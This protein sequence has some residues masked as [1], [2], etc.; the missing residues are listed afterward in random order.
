MLFQPSSKLPLDQFHT[1]PFSH[2]PGGNIYN[3]THNVSFLF[4]KKR[5][6]FKLV[7]DG[8]CQDLSLRQK[9]VLGVGKIA[10][11]TSLPY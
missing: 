4:L 6:D 10:L 9:V 11:Q 8:A 1:D 3:I 7:K 2:S 5:A